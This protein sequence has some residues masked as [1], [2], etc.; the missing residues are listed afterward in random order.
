[1]D[2]QKCPKKIETIENSV[3]TFQCSPVPTKRRVTHYPQLR[4][5][6][7]EVSVHLY[8]QTQEKEWLYGPRWKMNVLK[9]RTVW[10]NCLIALRQNHVDLLNLG[11][12]CYSITW[13]ENM[14]LEQWWIS[15]TRKWNI[16]NYFRGTIWR[17]GLTFS[18][19]VCRTQYI[20]VQTK[21]VM[22]W[23]GLSVKLNLFYCSYGRINGNRGHHWTSP[24]QPT[25]L[26]GYIYL[27]Y[28][29]P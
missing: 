25:F 17:H 14:F 28:G 2:P 16:W 11:I 4:P 18:E 9:I 6:W 21:E 12:M 10:K 20:L 3:S 8:N 22:I 26:G 29:Y 15:T 7:K 24:W 1:M 23:W 27:W 5:S 13:K 19:P